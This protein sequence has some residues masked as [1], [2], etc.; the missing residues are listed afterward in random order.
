MRKTLLSTLVVAVLLGVSGVGSAQDASPGGAKTMVTVSFSGYDD[1]LAKLGLVGK[2]GGSE[3]MFKVPLEKAIKDATGGKGLA[4]LDTAKPW[5]AL[6]QTDGSGDLPVVVFVPVTD[7]D[8]LL[9]ALAPIIG[10]PEDA[11]GGVK[12]IDLPG[13]PGGPQIPP[14]YVK[15][16]GGWAFVAPS[17]EM[18]ANPPADPLKALGG[19]NEKYIAA[20]QVSVGNL[21]DEMRDAIRSNMEMGA[22]VLNVPQPGESQEDYEIRTGMTKRMIEQMI[23]VLEDMDQVLLGW[24]VDEQASSSYV[25]FQVTAVEGSKTAALFN[26]PLP[27]KTN[28]A[29]FDLPGAAVTGSL[30]SALSDSDV[31]DLKNALA[32]LRA[33]AIKELAGQGLADAERQLATQLLGDL[34]D[35]L[36]TTIEKKVIDGGFTLMLEPGS[37]TLLAGGTIGDGDKLENLLMQFA[38]LAKQEDPN[39]AQLMKLDAE[40]HQG[41]RFHTL[42]V[43]LPDPDAVKF[44]GQNLDVVVGVNNDS[45]YLALGRQAADTLKQVIDKSKA[46]PGRQVPPF[47]LS[48]SLTPIVNFAAEATENP[49]QK[50]MIGMFGAM[51][52]QAG[53]KDHVTLTSTQIPNGARVRLEFEEGILKLIGG[54]GSMLGSA[55]SAPPGAS[56]F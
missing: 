43:P 13:G 44:F 28:F 41:V 9:E 37:V 25:D 31:T 52:Q 6:V 7:L 15:Q 24:A 8:Q 26:E 12:K 16:Q 30:A 32:T 27:G 51:L 5:G 4:G 17:L 49:G 38:E 11:G 35:V 45:L 23:T 3:D 39:L 1:L 34:L 47:R 56:P 33:R 54:A 46:E 10:Q 36:T 29:G 2:L 19:L 20:A 53:S 48:L 55:S 21:P 18:L 42:S 14:A 22:A 40:T 50:M